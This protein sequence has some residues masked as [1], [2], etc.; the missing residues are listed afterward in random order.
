MVLDIQISM[1]KKKCKKPRDIP[2]ASPVTNCEQSTILKKDI[3][4]TQ[5]YCFNLANQKEEGMGIKTGR[6]L[7]EIQVKNTN[8]SKPP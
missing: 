5:N 1:K 3:I 4:N 7:Q 2:L 6:S 8:E